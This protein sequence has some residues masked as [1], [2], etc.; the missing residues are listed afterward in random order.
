SI[1]SHAVEA[2]IISGVSET[3]FEPER[4]ITRE[5]MAIMLVRAY[6]WK[7]GVQDLSNA[8]ST[9]SD[10]THISSWAKEA[11]TKATEWKLLQ[12]KTDRLFFPQDKTTRAESTQAIYNLLNQM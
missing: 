11:V 9:Y 10:S 8:H 2:G 3:E 4:S 7:V 6:N 1:V 5:E 12:G